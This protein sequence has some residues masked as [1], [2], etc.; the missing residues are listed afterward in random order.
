M[1]A[2]LIR[3][4]L[5]TKEVHS[6]PDLE[7]RLASSFEEYVKAFVLLHDC[8]VAK[9]LMEKHPSKMRISVHSFLPHNHV[10][11]VIDKKIN[12]VIGTVSLILDNQL[13]IPAEGAYPQ[14]V[15]EIRKIRQGKMMEVSAL[16]VDPRYR[17]QSH[18]IQFM[19]NKYLS[20]YSR[21]I[22]NVK[23][24]IIV[25]HPKAEIFYRSL[26]GFIPLGEIISYNFVKGA[27][28]RFMYLDISEDYEIN[29]LKMYKNKKNTWADYM[30]KQNDVRLKISDE[31]RDD[32]IRRNSFTMIQLMHATFFQ[33][34]KLTTIE[35]SL[36]ISGLNLTMRDLENFELNFGNTCVSKYRFDVHFLA[37]LSHDNQSS[38][39]KIVNISEQGA[40]L[41]T[42]IDSIIMDQ[43]GSIQFQWKGKKFESK[44]RVAWI[45]RQ[46][47]N[48]V[49][50]GFG[51]QLISNKV[52]IFSENSNKK[53]A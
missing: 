45:N 20:L 2:R 40:F 26:M 34:S 48:K 11:V 1:Q 31:I 21:N 43:V 27:L 33:V 22:L 30:F 35:Q 19:L 50:V 37:K 41:E 16:A 29:I 23:M 44:Y 13:G 49:P 4:I 9:G 46:T 38:L 36:L 51:I 12:E 5:S 15:N 32:V 24:L 6:N 47:K 18:S 52:D 42:N 10:I 7:V 8:Y 53:T 25:I 3:N 28:A 17:H 39:V 14:E